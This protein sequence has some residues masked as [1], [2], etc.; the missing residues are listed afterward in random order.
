MPRRAHGL[1]P[2]LIAFALFFKLE[3]WLWDKAQPA[4]AALTDFVPW[5]RVKKDL[6]AEIGKRPAWFGLALLALP[7]VVLLPVKFLVV[8]LIA[9]RK[10]VVAGG[11][12]AAAKALDMGVTAFV[13]D[14]SKP[15]LLQIA[16]FRA[17]YNTMLRIREW[18]DEKVAG[19]RVR[20]DF[21]FAVIGD[22]VKIDRFLRLLAAMRRRAK[23]A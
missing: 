2:I 11:M 6:A 23:P 17:F 7:T 16:W 10:F 4:I 12:F 8:A 15:K 1:K 20:A 18:A 3:A 5:A 14:A 22:P 19:L 9:K 13:F 21:W